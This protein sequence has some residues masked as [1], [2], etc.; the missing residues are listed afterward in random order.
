MEPMNEGRRA[1]LQEYCKLLNKI[2]EGAPPILKCTESK[3]CLGGDDKIGH[4]YLDLNPRKMC[5]ACEAYWHVDCARIVIETIL[6][7][8]PRHE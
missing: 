7:F 3:W 2:I 5:N 6:K 8:T 4:G 1:Q